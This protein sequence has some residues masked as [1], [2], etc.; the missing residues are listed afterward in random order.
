M[1][2]L[3]LLTV[4]PANAQSIPKPSIPEFT[5]QWIDKSYDV[6]QTT[7]ID[8]Y[9]GKTII[10]PAHHVENKSIEFSIKN[11][12]WDDVYGIHYNIR[13]KGHFEVNW[14]YVFPINNSPTMNNSEY[15]NLVFTSTDG[16]RYESFSNSW[17]TIYAPSDGMLDFQV[18]AFV[19]G[20]VP[21]NS[22]Y[23]GMV[24]T[25]LEESDWSSAQTI[26]IPASSVDFAITLVLIAAAILVVVVVSLLLLIRHR[27]TSNLK[28]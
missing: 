18:K 15:T 22:M 19:R 12:K 11:Q 3:T 24:E 25:T 17:A 5:V 28:Q 1:S 27:K 21:S 4:K 13:V 10:N 7:S 2:C 14:T 9:T 20:Y 8:P 16:E 6:S 23:G 26:T